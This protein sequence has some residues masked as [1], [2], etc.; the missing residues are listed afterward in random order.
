MATLFYDHLIDWQRL[1]DAFAR[2]EL[3]PEE[4]AELWEHAEHTLHTEV[5][6]VFVSH[7]PKEKHE[8]FITRFHAAPFDSSHLHF[9][10]SHTT[11][12]VDSAVKERANAVINEMLAELS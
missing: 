1:E 2:L 7:L 3:E 9:V 6:M 4:R 8:E 12:D 10:V 5:I 11:S